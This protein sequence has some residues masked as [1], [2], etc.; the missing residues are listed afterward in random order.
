MTTTTTTKTIPALAREYADK[1]RV[2][3]RADG[4]EYYSHPDGADSPLGNLCRKAHGDMFPDDHRYEMIFK[5]LDA[6]G[7]AGEDAEET[8][9]WERVDQEDAPVYTN[10]LTGWLASHLHRVGYVDTGR[11]DYCQQGADTETQLRYGWLSEFREVAGLCL[12][13]LADTVGTPKA[14]FPSI[15]KDRL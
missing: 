12:A 4:S 10:Q 1:F 7:D 15:S 9:I 2:N 13:S 14:D 8:A 11:Q 6:I 3:T 5:A